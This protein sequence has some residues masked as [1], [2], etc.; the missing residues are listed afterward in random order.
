MDKI[1]EMIGERL[2]NDKSID[3]LK[4]LITGAKMPDTKDFS[5]F[6][7]VTMPDYN[8][9]EKQ[10]L[11]VCDKANWNF[12]ENWSREKKKV[13]TVLEK[14]T[15]KLEGEPILVI[16][17]NKEIAADIANWELEGVDSEEYMYYTHYRSEDTAG[18][19]LPYRIVVC[20][21]MPWTPESSYRTHDIMY[22][23]DEGTFR[24]IE[25]AD[26]FKNAV[27]RG[28]DPEGNKRSIVFVLGGRMEDVK[29]YFNEKVEVVETH[30]RGTL[31]KLAP[32]YAYYWLSE[33][34][35]QCKYEDFKVLPLVAEIMGF[36]FETRED[37]IKQGKMD[38][39]MCNVHSIST[40]VR[41]TI[42]QYLDGKP[43]GVDDFKRFFEEYKY[44]FPDHAQIEE[45]H[46]V[47]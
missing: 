15:Q 24:D 31:H 36:A 33:G 10:R 20:V 11:I 16:A 37:L 25:M 3:S 45:Q 26:T 39:T 47:I 12:E 19:R 23:E 2:A 5:N 6:V 17:I 21:G 43:F 14:L 30:K 40:L 44:M 29:K 41:K 4:I 1:H 34:E 46:V 8:E 38:E 7:E 13:K 27:G 9:T 35:H 22:D 32:A 18:V 42:G 28:K